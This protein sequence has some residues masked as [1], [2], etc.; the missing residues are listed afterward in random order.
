MRRAEN[1]DAFA[2]CD[3]CTLRTGSVYALGK[4]RD[5]DTAALCY[6]KTELAPHLYTVGACVSS[7]DDGDGGLFV[8]LGQSALYID[9]MRRGVYILEPHGITRVINGDYFYVLHTASVYRAQSRGKVTL[10]QVLRTLS[11]SAEELRYLALWCFVHCLGVSVV[12]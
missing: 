10:F 3:K 12:L 9:D 1:A 7:T 2:V 6:L 8:Y 5:N 4:A 11:P